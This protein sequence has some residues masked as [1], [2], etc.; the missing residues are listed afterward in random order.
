MGCID[1]NIETADGPFAFFLGLYPS[2]SKLVM[3][4][5]LVLGCAKLL[6]LSFLNET[7]NTQQRH[8]RVTQQQQRQQQQHRAA[9]ATGGDRGGGGLGGGGAAAVLVLADAR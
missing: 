8:K 1:L 7:Q 3:G 6:F 9:A 4:L 2:K 5:S